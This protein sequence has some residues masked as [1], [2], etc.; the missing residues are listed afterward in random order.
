MQIW[1][2]TKLFKFL[3]TRMSKAIAQILKEEGFIEDFE[4]LIQNRKSF[5]FIN[6]FKI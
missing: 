1:L 6:F 3:S 5:A 2:N 4:D